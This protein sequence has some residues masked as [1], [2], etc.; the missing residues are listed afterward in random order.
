[1]QCLVTWVPKEN[2][3]KVIVWFL[4]NNFEAKIWA[5]IFPDK[6]ALWEESIKDCAGSNL[7]TGFSNFFLF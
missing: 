3:T 5:K 7:F 2:P 6:E 4:K 1:M